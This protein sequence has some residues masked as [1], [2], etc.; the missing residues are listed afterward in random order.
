MYGCHILYQVILLINSKAK[1]SKSISC[2]ILPVLFSLRLKR[3]EK[4]DAFAGHAILSLL[5]NFA[6]EH[7]LFNAVIQLSHL[8][9]VISG[10]ISGLEYLVHILK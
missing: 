7:L 6:G 2:L 3:A 5:C 10:S 9:G 1:V 4:T 8:I